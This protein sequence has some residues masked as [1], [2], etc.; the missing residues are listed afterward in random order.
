MQQFARIRQ[1]ATTI[2]VLIRNQTLLD[3]RPIVS[4]ITPETIASGSLTKIEA[5]ELKE[6]SGEVTYLEPIA[7]IRQVAATGFNYKKHIEELKVPAPTEPEVFLKSTL[8]LTGPLDPIRRGPSVGAKLDWETELAIVVG[9]EVQDIDAVDAAEYIFGYTC[10]NDISDR[11]TQV[12]AA[13]VQHLVRAK[14]RPTYGPIGPYL[15]TGIDAMSLDVWTKLNGNYE[16]QGNTSDML[17][18]IHEMLAYFSRYMR[19]LP[20]D[21][22]ATGTPP[23]VGMGKNRYMAVGDILECGITHLGAQRHEIIA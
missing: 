18:H 4:D 6:L 22:L 20:G 9:R 17:F 16:Q 23:G 10:I 7:G 3:L 15:T 8:S 2:P 5:G 21:I 13:H 11:A 14:S 1:A 12:D 19:L